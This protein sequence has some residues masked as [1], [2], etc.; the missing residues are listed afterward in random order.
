[1][2]SPDQTTVYV[3]KILDIFGGFIEY[4]FT[5]YNTQPYIEG[6]DD[7]G[8][9]IRIDVEIHFLDSDVV[10]VAN[11][12]SDVFSQDSGEYITLSDYRYD[13][14]VKTIKIRDRHRTKLLKGLDEVED[15]LD[16]IS[17]SYLGSGKNT[18]DESRSILPLEVPTLTRC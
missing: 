11:I 13:N 3:V 8:N 9:D 6:V 4:F 7:N 18:L 15:L 10:K 12:N 2:L 5:S 14:G 16:R 1:M 17:N